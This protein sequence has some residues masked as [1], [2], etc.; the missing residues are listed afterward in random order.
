[1][2]IPSEYQFT[3]DIAEKSS[4]DVPFLFY[5]Y[6]DRDGT[7]IDQ[8]FITELETPLNVY[9]IID[10]PYLQT[11]KSE[12]LLDKAKALIDEYCRTELESEEGADYTDLSKVN[13]VYTTTE[14]DKHKIQAMLP[15]SMQGAK[16]Y[17]VEI[18]KISAGIAQQLYQR[19]SIAAQPYEEANV[20]D[21]FFDAVVGNVPFGDIRLADKRYD[22]YHFLIHDYFFAKSLDKLRPGGIMAL[23]TSKGTMDKENPAI[24]KY[25]AQRADLLGAV[26]LPNNTFK[27]MPEP[28][29][30]RYSHLAEA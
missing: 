12:T 16:M 7:T 17:G 23:V 30:C 18:D 13:V 15:P 11:G 27:A 2:S 28:R 9:E 3:K 10:S 20:P 26:R 19:T 22:K 8:G 14:D 1:M 5:V 25:I 29:L 24:R 4:S 6:R 21:S